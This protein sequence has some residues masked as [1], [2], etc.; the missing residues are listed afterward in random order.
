MREEYV[1]PQVVQIGSV[2]SLTLSSS[3]STGGDDGSKPG[4]RIDG[5]GCT[6]VPQG[7]G[8]NG[9]GPC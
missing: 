1:R 4:T 6:L 8:N 2:A 7:Q 9:N 5:S 3:G